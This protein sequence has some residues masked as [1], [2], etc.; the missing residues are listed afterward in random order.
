MKEQ[1]VQDG[2]KQ[3]A[4]DA[5]TGY[6]RD[7]GVDQYCLEL[8]WRTVIAFQNYP[9]TTC[10]RGTRPG[11]AFR[12]TVSVDVGR[13]G[14]RYQG[15]CV[16]GYGNELFIDGKERSISRSTV[17]LAFRKG[18]EVMVQEGR[19]SGPRKL[20]VPGARSYLYGMFLEFGVIRR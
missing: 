9:F 6:L 3:A 2:E 4:K 10:G 18:V 13:S 19:V 12:Y 20:G 7:H 8:L 11:I 1:Q 15:T 17:E 5:L 14:R 16:D